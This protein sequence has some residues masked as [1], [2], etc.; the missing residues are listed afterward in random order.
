ML[1][2]T[3]IH[4][5]AEK[6]SKLLAV[7]LK[8]LPD[9]H[10][11]TKLFIQ[12]HN[13]RHQ[14]RMI[15][16]FGFVIGPQIT[17]QILAELEHNNPLSLSTLDLMAV[18]VVN[19]FWIKRQ[20]IVCGFSRPILLCELE[21]IWFINYMEFMKEFLPR[22]LTW[23]ILSAFIWATVTVFP[24]TFVGFSFFITFFVI[25]YAY[26]GKIFTNLLENWN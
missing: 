26:I 25:L 2:Q 21:M 7:D 12:Q 18:N 17:F 13:N 10:F 24:L 15:R 1:G 22:G 23:V 16:F 14:E 3:R 4:C 6:V 11:F 20:V 8:Y 5:F 9:F 19:N